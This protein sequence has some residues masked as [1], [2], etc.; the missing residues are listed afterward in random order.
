MKHLPN[1]E[2]NKS[3]PGISRKNHVAVYVIWEEKGFG[4]LGKLTNYIIDQM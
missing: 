1:N 3:V 4:G 2:V